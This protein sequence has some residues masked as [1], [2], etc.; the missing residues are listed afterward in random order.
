M[1]LLLTLIAAI[2]STMV[3][4][5]SPKA[6]ELQVGALLYMFWGAALMWMADAIFEFAELGAEYFA[7][8]VE[9]MTNDTFLGLSVIVLA[10]VIW[11]AILLVKDPLNSVK[12]FV[13]SRS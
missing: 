9:D 11:V 5:V 8:S 3:W 10:L 7:P 4:Y 2:I 12:G 6:R 1:T 13:K